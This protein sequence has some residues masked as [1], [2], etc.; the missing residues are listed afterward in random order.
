[1][2]TYICMAVFGHNCAMGI[3]QRTYIHMCMDGCMYVSTYTKITIKI[4]N[5]KVL[6]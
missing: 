1:M 2:H 3:Y 5:I 4:F 6:C